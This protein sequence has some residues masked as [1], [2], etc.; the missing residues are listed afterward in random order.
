MWGSGQ[1]VGVWSG[2]EQ[3]WSGC[4]GLVRV[5]GSGQGVGRSGQGVGRSGQ[6]VGVW[7]GCGGLVRVRA[8]LVRV[9]AG[10]VRVWGGG[11]PF[12]ERAGCVCTFGVLT[13]QAKKQWIVVWKR[14][15]PPGRTAGS[16]NNTKPN[17]S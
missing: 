7:S 10:L 8:G 15:V 16:D 6:G 1:G 13:I 3:V 12:A 14:N 4:G 9:W 17:H 2:C 11:P 5:W